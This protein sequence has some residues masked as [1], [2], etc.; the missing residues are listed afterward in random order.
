MNQEYKTGKC[1]EE[2]QRGPGLIASLWPGL[3]A[4]LSILAGIAW[5]VEHLGG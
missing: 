3:F 5:L 1:Y 2:H 4:A